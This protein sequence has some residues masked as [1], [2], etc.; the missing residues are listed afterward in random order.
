MTSRVRTFLAAPPAK[1]PGDAPSF[2]ELHTVKPAWS[3]KPHITYGIRQYP[4]LSTVPYDLPLPLHRQGQAF[5]NCLAS[6]HRTADL[7]SHEVQDRFRAIGTVGPSSGKTKSCCMIFAWGRTCDDLLRPVSDFAIGE[8]LRA[9]ASAS[10]T[11]W[12]ARPPGTPHSRHRAAVCL[13]VSVSVPARPVLVLARD[14]RGS[15][16][17]TLALDESSGPGASW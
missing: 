5:T 17:A 15:G 12:Y 10:N 14:C 11:I 13:T 8:C 7:N 2:S 6:P 3:K 16:K 4:V 1:R 9:R